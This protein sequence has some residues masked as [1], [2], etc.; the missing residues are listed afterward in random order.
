MNVLLMC[1]QRFVIDYDVVHMCRIEGW[2]IGRAIG[3]R[4]RGFRYRLVCRRLGQV[5]MQCIWFPSRCSD[6]AL[7][8]PRARSYDPLDR[9]I[10]REEGKLEPLNFSSFS[11]GEL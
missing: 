5:E 9:H 10:D 11:R 8:R 6:L 7:V 1:F 2:R 4:R 3:G